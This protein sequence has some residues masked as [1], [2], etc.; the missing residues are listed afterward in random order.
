MEQNFVDQHGHIWSTNE[1]V[2][3][4]NKEDQSSLGSTGNGMF[5]SELNNLTPGRTY[6][7]RAYLI[8]QEEEK[9]GMVQSFMIPSFA[10]QMVIDS[11]RLEQ[12]SS[13][14]TIYTTIS[15]LTEGTQLLSY[16]LTWGENPQPTLEL[17]QISFQQG[18]VVSEPEFQFESQISLNPGVNYVRP[19]VEVGDATLYGP[20]S[21]VFNGNVWTQRADFQGA[22]RVGAVGFSIG[23]KGY[24]GTGQDESRDASADFWEYDPQ[25]NLW[26]QRADVGGGPRQNAV[27][28]SMGGKGY[29]GTGRGESIDFN[30]DFWEYDPQT[31]SWTRRADLEGEPR[32]NAV[33]FSIGG[34]GL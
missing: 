25:A 5:E 19:Y 29:I 6:F 23:G 17:D 7:Y 1:G 18:L 20:D 8:Y 13:L 3:L 27:G 30:N 12:N 31:N 24:I 26:T 14:S 33:G 11:V 28:F 21:R 32:E 16:G 15:G 9:Y 4:D 34:K 22:V 2:S 10:A